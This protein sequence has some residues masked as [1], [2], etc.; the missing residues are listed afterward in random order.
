MGKITTVIIDMYGVILRE[1]T[2]NFVPYTFQHFDKS[3]HERL[4]KQFEE[5]RLFTKAGYGELTSEEFLTKLGYQNP[6][7]H[8]RDYIENY[9]TLDQTFLSFAEK[10][11]RNFTTETAAQEGRNN[12]ITKQNINQ[13]TGKSGQ[14]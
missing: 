11:Y 7:Y 4:K 8:M 13:Y 14:S 9:L 3:Q 2:G 10:Y 6:E 1:R 12:E 5:E